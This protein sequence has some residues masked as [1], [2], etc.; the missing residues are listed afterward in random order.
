[1]SKV[2]G[3]PRAFGADLINIVEFP[4]LFN[5]VTPWGLM[6]APAPGAGRGALVGA[7]F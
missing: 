3:D 6:P 4:P 2:E 5:G 1:M 7:S